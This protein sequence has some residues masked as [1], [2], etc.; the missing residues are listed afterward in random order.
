MVM[1]VGRAC[2]VLLFLVSFVSAA[3]DVFVELTT[4]H[5]KAWIDP[6]EIATLKCYHP[7][8]PDVFGSVR[9]E[10]SMRSGHVEHLDFADKSTQQLACAELRS[11]I[12]KH[13][14]RP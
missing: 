4:R 14:E 11:A 6:R 12:R 13:Q 8:K 1:T 3:E 2:L 7:D 10:V 5:Y 9:I